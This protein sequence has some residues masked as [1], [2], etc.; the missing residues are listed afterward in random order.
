MRLS[1]GASV[2]VESSTVAKRSHMP[3]PEEWTRGAA[4]YSV[5][6]GMVAGLRIWFNRGRALADLGLD[7]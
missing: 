3:R 2:L 7:V 1:P 5:S 4:V 6:D